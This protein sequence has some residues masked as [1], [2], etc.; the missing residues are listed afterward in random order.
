MMKSL[1]CKGRNEYFTQRYIE[2]SDVG[3]CPNHEAPKAVSD[4]LSKWIS[5]TEPRRK[6]T[7]QL[8]PDEEHIMTEPWG[9]ISLREVDDEDILSMNV[10][11]TFLAQYISK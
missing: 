7:L 8:L 3:H 1:N 4:V 10:V 2:L 6:K 5:S 11:D 9:D